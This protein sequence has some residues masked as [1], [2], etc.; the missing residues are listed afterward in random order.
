M[1]QSCPFE[2]NK[3]IVV[4][5]LLSGRYVSDWHARKWSK[6]NPDGLCLLCPGDG[7][8]G[9][10]EHL[11]THCKALNEKRVQMVEYWEQQCVG[12]PDLWMLLSS[13]LSSTQQE[14]VQFLLDPSVLP[15]V[16]S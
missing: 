2:T 14:L 9:D 1:T 11:L 7:V 15:A 12:N 10:V 5:Q 6:D 8:P 16:I 3:A 4:C 13:F